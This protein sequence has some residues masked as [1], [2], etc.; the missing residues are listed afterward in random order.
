MTHFAG[1]RSPQA[2]LEIATAAPG[3]ISL[4][5]AEVTSLTDAWSI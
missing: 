3:S 2:A 5:F 1:H 4:A